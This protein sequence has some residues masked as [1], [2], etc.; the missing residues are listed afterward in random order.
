MIT[1]LW[2][3][4][5]LLL[6]AALVRLAFGSN[7][8]LEPSVLRAAPILAL[9]AVVFLIAMSYAEVSAGSIGIVMRLGKPVRE[10]QP[11]PH[12]VVP[13]TDTVT[14]VSVQ[15]HIVKP[16]EDAASLDLQVV[17]TEVTLAYHVDPAYATSILVQLN[18]DA[19]S[20]VIV[21]AIL[22]AIKARTA[23][24]DAQDLIS[25]RAEV[26]DGIE[27]FVRTRLMPYHIVAEN[28]SITDFRFSDEYEKAIEAKVTAAQQAEK[29][30]N[31]LAR[32]KIEAEQKVAAAQG[33]A[34]AL[35]VQKS[36]ITPELIQLRTIEM[37]HDKWD[38]HMPEVMT[39]SGTLPMLD[40]LKAAGK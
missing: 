34:Q 18:D 4:F 38:G 15:T 8:T 37:L 20:R 21:P 9:C 13:I 3:L 30:Q 17:H 26:R 23:Q 2:I 28:V 36:Q 32:I 7:W 29:A 24:Y 1:F 40:V 39:G 33:E 11:G 14:A 12:L 35:E 31:D 10:L 19:E 5:V 16:S 6:A 25:K 22:E 27:E